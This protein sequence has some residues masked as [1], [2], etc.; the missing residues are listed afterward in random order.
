MSQ[1]ALITN[2]P[3]SQ[4]S[5]SSRSL[6][7]K[8]VK[9]VYGSVWKEYSSWSQEYCQQIL[10]SLSTPDP[11]YSDPEFKDKKSTKPSSSASAS[12]AT[13]TISDYV[14]GLRYSMH[15]YSIDTQTISLNELEIEKATPYA[16]YHSCTSISQ[17]ILVGDDSDYLPFIPFAD[18]ENYKYSQD[19]DLHNYNAWQRPDLTFDG[20][21][22]AFI[23]VL[24]SILNVF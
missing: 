15:A 6:N 4:N 10:Q 9:R 17:N 21:N 22:S 18:D 11:K 19:F 12:S 16:P 7:S 13:C 24:I 23:V 5:P 1:R 14:D 20:V 3:I 8:K 2:D